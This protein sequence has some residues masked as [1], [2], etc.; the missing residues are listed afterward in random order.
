[1]RFAT[2]YGVMFVVRPAAMLAKDAVSYTGPRTTLDVS[3]TFTEMLAIALLGAVSFV[4][5]YE[6]V[7]RRAERHTA[8]VAGP[9]VDFAERRSSQS[10]S[11]PSASGLA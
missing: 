9:D 8:T 6:L 2:A 1:M 5:A 11:R 3:A 10:V 4:A 7:L